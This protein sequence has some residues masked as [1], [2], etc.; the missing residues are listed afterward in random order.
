ML[1][2]TRL[3]WVRYSLLLALAAISAA[4]L[5]FS[6]LHDALAPKQLF[7]FLE[8]IRESPAA[9][10]IFVGGF[11]LLSLL[12]S[13][14][15]PMIVAGGA[16]FG[17]AT[18]LLLNYLGVVMGASASYWVARLVGRDLARRLLS[19]RWETLESL[20][21]KR[22]F[23]PLVSLRFVPVPFP[24]ANYGSAL[25]GV[26]YSLFLISTAVAY[27]PILTVYGYFA[28]TLVRTDEAAHDPTLRK[29]S[30]ALLL[31]LLVT[32]V[33][34]RIISWRERSRARRLPGR[35]IVDSQ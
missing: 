13:P 11:V 10:F 18:G 8:R 19:S 30:L 14:L 23:W 3:P 16:V 21:Q 33:P 9:P 27:A 32:L 17:F 20:I 24:V 5:L 25:L 12:G 6:P 1:A 26:G 34:P 7:D 22:G 2:T 28:A 29:L 15:I 35:D 4:L 31:M